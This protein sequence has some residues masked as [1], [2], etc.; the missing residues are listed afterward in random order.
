FVNFL[1]RHLQGSESTCVLLL[2]T[3]LFKES[4]NADLELRIYR[5]LNSGSYCKVVYL[6]SAIQA[7]E[8]NQETLMT[9]ALAEST[10]E[11]ESIND[12]MVAATESSIK[13]MLKGVKVEAGDEEDCMICLEELKV[14][15]EAFRMPSSHA[16][17]GDCIE[18]WL[19]QSHYCPICR[20]E[21]QTD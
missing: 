11:L 9:R 6:H 5:T 14:G 7:S 19:M 15:F 16:F 4:W 8:I 3:P 20:F 17:H 21:K 10:S 12:G 13:E 18:K 1:F 2:T